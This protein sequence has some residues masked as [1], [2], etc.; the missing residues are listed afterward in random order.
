[1]TVKAMLGLIA[2][3]LWVWFMRLVVYGLKAMRA[4]HGRLQ[5]RG[6]ILLSTVS[7]QPLVLIASDLC[8][9]INRCFLGL[10]ADFSR[11][12][13]AEVATVLI[14]ARHRFLRLQHGAD[15]AALLAVK[16]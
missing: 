9:I 3:L 12:L 13:Y 2:L 6:V 1:M 8:S 14:V 15:R 16:G 11:A 7:T 4:C 5:T 10:S